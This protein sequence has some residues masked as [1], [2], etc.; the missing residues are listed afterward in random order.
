VPRW[1]SVDHR[2]P[3]SRNERSVVL[4]RFGDDRADLAAQALRTGDDLADAVMAEMDG[5][6]SIVARQLNDGLAHGLSSVEAPTPAVES[7]LRDV[8]AIADRVDARVIDRGQRPYFTVPD[9]VH[10]LS[11]STAAL[12]GGFAAGNIADT[13]AVTSRLITDAQKRLTEDGKWLTMAMLPGSLRPGA[14]GYAATVQV[15]I[16]HARI[17]HRARRQG[18]DE[19]AHGVPI[20]QL[21]LAGT[22]LAF[23]HRTFRA[24]AALGY[25]LTVDEQA[26]AYGYWQHL[27]HLLG[28]EPTLIGA[29]TSNDE[30]AAVDELI[31]ACMGPPTP[32][33]LALTRA[34][35]DAMAEAVHDAVHLPAVSGRHIL[36]A[37]LR[38]FNGDTIADALQVPRR[39]ET[40]LLIDGVVNVT[41]RHRE[42]LR[43]HEHTWDQMIEHNLEQARESLATYYAVDAEYETAMRTGASTTSPR[44]HSTSSADGR[45]P[46][47]GQPLP[48]RGS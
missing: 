25:G 4:D 7:L 2:W 12:G 47:A 43:K 19:A 38:R 15:R 28:I 34:T 27:G 13:L 46:G 23:T 40:N 16:H 14:G 36:E 1:P 33:S 11:L 9:V 32:S 31:W 20:N 39:P 26:E 35:I 8:E 45:A 18:F 41:R 10:T 21:D 48:D 6:G 44:S 17:R 42:H 24:E 3:T 30:A 5:H 29:I 37:L 22:W